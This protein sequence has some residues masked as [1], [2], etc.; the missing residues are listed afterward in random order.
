MGDAPAYRS[1]LR[2]RQ[3]A[4]TR[5]SIIAAA[6]RLFAE[7]GW[8]GTTLAA[9]A[10]QAGT[11]I[12]TIY[13]GFGSKVGLLLAAIDVAIAGDDDQS[14]V[15]ERPEFA[16]LGVGSRLDRLRAAAA[17]A[18]SSLVRAVPLMRALRE[19]AA[20]DETAKARLDAYETDRHTTI[21]VGLELVLGEAPSGEAVDSMWAV[22][23]PEVFVKLTQERGWS[24]ERYE[25]WLVETAA[26]MLGGRR[27]DAV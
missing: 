22:A 12:E 20:S 15:A 17:V 11:A 5:Q 1:P 6:A 27:D 23:G 8:A 4:E 10:G 25:R 21:A 16:R 18:A 19:A 26:A 7:R 13:S 9:V 14:P 24:T 2:A 3:A